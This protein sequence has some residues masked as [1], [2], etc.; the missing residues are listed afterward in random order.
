MFKDD[1]DVSPSTSLANLFTFFD[2][3]DYKDYSLKLRESGMN[4]RSRTPHGLLTRAHGRPHLNLKDYMELFL[5]MVSG[6]RNV[7]GGYFYGEYSRKLIYRIAFLGFEGMLDAIAAEALD[8]S[9]EQVPKRKPDRK[10]ERNSENRIEKKQ[11]ILQAF[12]LECRE[13]GLQ[14]YL[15]PLRYRVDVQGAPLSLARDEMLNT[16]K[17]ADL[18]RENGSPE[19]DGTENGGTENAI[20]GNAS[21]I[22]ASVFQ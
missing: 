6:K 19:N 17:A 9:S 10:L 22:Q 12:H 3:T 7:H 8:Y 1:Y 21:K 5:D 13:K 2:C 15:S 14:A 11:Q 18:S 16:V 20:V 4:E